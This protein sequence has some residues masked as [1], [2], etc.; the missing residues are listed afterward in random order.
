MTCRDRFCSPLRLDELDR[1]TPSRATDGWMVP[2]TTRAAWDTTGQAELRGQAGL[3][4]QVWL[5]EQAAQREV[6]ANARLGPP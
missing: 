2:G 4:G 1:K 3:R 6:G 5:Q